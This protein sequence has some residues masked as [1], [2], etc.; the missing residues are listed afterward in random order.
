VGWLIGLRTAE[1]DAGV[2]ERR[3]KHQLRLVCPGGPSVWISRYAGRNRPQ[4]S[5]PN[6][7]RVI[8]LCHPL[9]IPSIVIKTDSGKATSMRKKLGT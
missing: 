7:L 4:R 1:I 3:A 5:S 8:D 2:S 9:I 6:P